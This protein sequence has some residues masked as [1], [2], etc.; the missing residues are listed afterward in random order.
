MVLSEQLSNRLPTLQ[1]RL[2]DVLPLLP[3]QVTHVGPARRQR[4]HRLGSDELGA[5]ISAYEGGM[6]MK[7]VGGMYGVHESTICT[8]LHRVGLEARTGPMFGGDDVAQI[9][10]EYRSG[11]S[12]SQVAAR[13]GC[14]STTILRLLQREGVECRP[15]GAN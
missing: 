15:P 8:L 7:Q 14:S 6:S 3:V 2:L 11:L 9:C 4:Q 10:E 5:A 12:L 13:H 1:A